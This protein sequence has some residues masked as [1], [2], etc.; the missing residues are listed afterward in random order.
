[1]RTSATDSSV[2]FLAAILALLERIR[3]LETEAIG[4]EIVLAIGGA[5]GDGAEGAA[6]LLEEQRQVALLQL[7][8]R[9]HQ[10]DGRRAE[11]RLRIGGAERSEPRQAFDHVA[12][13]LAQP[14][15]RVDPQPRHEIVR[16]E[17]S[18]AQADSRWRSSPSRAASIVTPAAWRCPPNR[19]NTSAQ[20]SSAPSRSN[21][22]MLRPDP[23]ATPS[24]IDEH[25]RRLAVDLDELRRDDA[26][27]AA[28]PAVRRRR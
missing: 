7:A 13:D 20:A 9:L 6:V 11:D 27:D 19:R 28:V 17:R 18:L 21:A 8:R 14:E 26:D 15:R 10:I 1:M 5:P 2:D 12:G 4:R 3:E 25:E 24:S 16:A 22:G 23:C